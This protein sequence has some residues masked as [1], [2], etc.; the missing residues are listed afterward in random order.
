M[1]SGYAT[2][3]LTKQRPDYDSLNS[4]DKKLLEEFYADIMACLTGIFMKC[5]VEFL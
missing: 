4:K 2:G 3:I 5:D 1:P